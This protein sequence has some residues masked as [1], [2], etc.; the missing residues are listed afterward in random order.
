M[1]AQHRKVIVYEGRYSGTPNRYEKIE[2]G[3]GVFIQF[4]LAIEEDEKGFSNYS[5]AIVE[6]PDG[7][8]LTPPPTMIKF[9]NDESES[10][11]GISK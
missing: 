7:T 1:S 5:V 11:N 9:I 2:Y 8:V 6:M 4:G 10:G 3:I